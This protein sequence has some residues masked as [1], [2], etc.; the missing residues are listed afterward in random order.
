MDAFTLEQ[1]DSVDRLTWSAH[2][3]S[4]TLSDFIAKELNHFG[5]N[6][7][8]ATYLS[9]LVKN[10]VVTNVSQVTVRLGKNDP[11]VVEN[12]LRMVGLALG[13]K[14][15][16]VSKLPSMLEL[17]Q[18]PVD[19]AFARMVS[20]YQGHRASSQVVINKTPHGQPYMTIDASASIV[21]K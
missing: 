12:A 19:F 14:G 16:T 15:F 10:N 13:E 21:F 11:A 20:S 6:G 18:R 9:T 2:I 3:A 1:K 4:S 5:V 17:L 7:A 8:R